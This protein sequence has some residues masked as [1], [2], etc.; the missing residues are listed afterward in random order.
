MPSRTARLLAALALH[1]E[2]LVVDVLLAGM[3][4]PEERRSMLMALR[5]LEQQG[6][7]VRSGPRRHH[8]IAGV[9]VRLATTP[10]KGDL[11]RVDSLYS[12]FVLGVPEGQLVSSGQTPRAFRAPEK[13][14][15]L[16]IPG[17]SSR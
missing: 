17:G 4:A 2:G 6:K 12:L 13:H 5:T 14:G 9:L 3:S 15:R 8:Y 11:S 7:V 10:D 16:T 1:P